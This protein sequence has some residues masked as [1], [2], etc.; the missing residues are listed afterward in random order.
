MLRILRPFFLFAVL[1]GLSGFVGKYWLE[2]KLKTQLDTNFAKLRSFADISYAKVYL[3][4]DGAVNIDGLSIA[5]RDSQYGISFIE[6][7]RLEPSSRLYFLDFLLDNKPQLPQG[8]NVEISQANLGV[9]ESQ[10]LSGFIDD[11]NTSA[12]ERYQPICGD[13]Q[14]LGPKDWREMG[15]SNLTSD[16]TFSYA[17][18]KANNSLH[19][20]MTWTKE[21][22]GAM[23]LRST[24]SNVPF[25]AQAILSGAKP[26]L[27]TF[28]VS[29]QDLGYGA[30]EL[31]YCSNKMSVTPELYATFAS[32]REASYFHEA[33]GIT[34][35]PKMR[36]AYK[37]FILQPK[38]F[39]LTMYPADDFDFSQLPV[40]QPSDWPDLLRI[41]L[42]VND[43]T[44]PLDI[45][46]PEASA[47]ATSRANDT[48][49]ESTSAAVS[50]G[51]SW[52]QPK[53]EVQKYFRD[54]EKKDIAEKI[55]QRIR[56]TSV[57][58]RVRE[59]TFLGVDKG[60]L[61]IQTDKYGSKMT[62]R[63]SL[64]NTERIEVLE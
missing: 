12:A 57:S 53:P 36:L 8:L 5:P 49:T 47:K 55:G 24:M 6:R 50:E 25:S 2:N 29:Y 3:D 64:Y 20:D 31:A 59:G 13:V 21:T 54:V 45:Q 60:D 10:F 56:V 51:R 1:V 23:Q 9:F 34:P 28:E 11:A 17:N 35:G 48:V 42:Q 39:S 15:Y 44:V 43:K 62:L 22:M 61:K 38:N 30:K 41:N 14:F 4:I 52:A 46:N 37:D 19:L 58:G 33:H 32:N 16:I 63:V 7:I 40:F 27:Q 26:Q 18:D